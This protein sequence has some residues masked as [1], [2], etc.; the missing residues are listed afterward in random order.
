MQRNLSSFAGKLSKEAK[1]RCK[2][3]IGMMGGL[4]PVERC[5]ERR[6]HQFRSQ[7]PGCLFSLT[8]V[9]TAIQ[10]KTQKSLEGYCQFLCDWVKDVR[11]WKV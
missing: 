10:F 8:K 7:R 9:L 2:R 1:T 3:E 11:L 6:F 4:D 5:V